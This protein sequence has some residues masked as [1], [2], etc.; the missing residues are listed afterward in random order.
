EAND[1][2]EQHTPT[3]VGWYKPDVQSALGAALA[4]QRN[5]DAAEPLLIAGYEGLRDLPETPPAHLRVAVERL[6]AFCVESGRKDEA[7]A[8]R[9][10][11]D[12]LPAAQPRASVRRE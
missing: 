2:F 11:L 7:A 8:W 5:F 3:R 10:R 4:G 9:Q 1:I 12:A 6:V